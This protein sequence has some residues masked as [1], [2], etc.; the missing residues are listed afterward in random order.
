MV[1]VLSLLWTLVL[2]I[3]TTSVSFFYIQKEFRHGFPFSFARETISDS[4]VASYTFNYWSVALDIFVWWI[5]FS[6]IWIIVKN[7]ILELD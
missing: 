5:L 1:R 6:M 3:L 7:Y 4:G 2:A